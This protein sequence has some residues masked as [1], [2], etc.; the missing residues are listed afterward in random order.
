[1][2]RVERME[3][4]QGPGGGGGA[5]AMVVEEDEE[6]AWRR[7]MAPNARRRAGKHTKR[8]IVR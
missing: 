7:P 8:V 4:T 6:E 5:E 1:M 2:E 3:R